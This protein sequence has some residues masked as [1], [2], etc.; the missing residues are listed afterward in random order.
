M[1]NF[2]GS[3]FSEELLDNMDRRRQSVF[4]RDLFLAAMF[5]DPRFSFELDGEQKEKAIKHLLYIQ[6]KLEGKL[7]LRITK[8]KTPAYRLNVSMNLISGLQKD[9]DISDS[10][11]VNTLQSG[12][13]IDDPTEIRY[14]K[15][16]SQKHKTKL[17]AS[18]SA[19]EFEIICRTFNPPR[20]KIHENVLQFWELNKN[21]YPELYPVAVVIFAVPCTQVSTTRMLSQLKFIQSPERNSWAPDIM[22]DILLLNANF[23]L[24]FLS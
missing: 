19:P 8:C 20:L 15:F 14:E 24:N 11:P 9:N 3:P 17:Q 23:R 13:D 1:F 18:A 16:L 4:E 5:L 2:V 6:S 7:T 10:A 12:C 21:V 22:D